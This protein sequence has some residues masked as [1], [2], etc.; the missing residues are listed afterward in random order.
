MIHVYYKYTSK[1]CFLSLTNAKKSKGIQNDPH[2]FV[3]LEF[4]QNYLENV[5]LWRNI[6]HNSSIQMMILKILKL[7]L[8][9]LA[10]KLGTIHKWR[11]L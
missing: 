1:N 4:L 3:F 9:K 7:F 10:T 6:V 5:T 2:Y 11:R 8:K